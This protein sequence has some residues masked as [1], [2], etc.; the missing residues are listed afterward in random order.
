VI[1]RG[2]SSGRADRFDLARGQARTAAPREKHDRCRYRLLNEAAH[3]LLVGSPT[4]PTF[5]PIPFADERRR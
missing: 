2:S 1:E 4:T 5:V 3:S